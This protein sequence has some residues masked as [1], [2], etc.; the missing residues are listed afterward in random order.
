[1]PVAAF[2]V[3]GDD[4][5]VR[6]AGCLLGGTAEGGQE[7]GVVVGGQFAVGGGGSERDVLSCAECAGQTGV[8][9]PQV[10]DAVRSDE[11]FVIARLFGVL[12]QDPH[13]CHRCLGL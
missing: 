5:V 12:A 4:D 2:V 11:D 13:M 3:C 7:R 10:H 1:M 6:G 9:E 8:R